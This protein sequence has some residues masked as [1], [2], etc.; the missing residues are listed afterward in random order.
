MY[1]TFENKAGSPISRPS[2]Q[3][4][5]D[6]LLCHS[7]LR[8]SEVKF[9]D[10]IF[11]EKQEIHSNMILFKVPAWISIRFKC[12][13][14]FPGR[15][16]WNF[17][18]ATIDLPP[19]LILRSCPCTRFPQKTLI[20]TIPRK[21][22]SSLKH[23]TFL[24]NFLKHSKWAL[25]L[26]FSCCT[27]RRIIARFFAKGRQK[28]HFTSRGSTGSA[29]NGE[30]DQ[31]CECPAERCREDR[32]SPRGQGLLALCPNPIVSSWMLGLETYLNAPRREIGELRE[33][34]HTVTLV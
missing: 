1:V 22:S 15:K 33:D 28:R 10:F 14:V 24:P 23:G 2:K 4:I 31:A 5:C 8:F 16:P 26:V 32:D 19:R 29:L 17:L 3:S 6:A 21:R 9:I 25:H 34:V 11:P 20:Q 7:S 12:T 30:K 13:I 27:T 18:H